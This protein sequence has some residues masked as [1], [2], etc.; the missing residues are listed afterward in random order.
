M[1]G[2]DAPAG[3]T[4]QAKASTPDPSSIRLGGPP[5]T[6]TS[7]SS[8][9]EYVSST[10]PPK[11]VIEGAPCS[12]GPPGTLWIGLEASWAEPPFR[13]TLPVRADKDRRQVAS[14]AADHVERVFGWCLGRGEA[15][16][17]IEAK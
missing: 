7:Q 10:F 3:S 8:N 16:S 4:C 12:C 6:E 13:L 5:P 14:I 2:M 1:G 17:G 9:L 15:A 11:V